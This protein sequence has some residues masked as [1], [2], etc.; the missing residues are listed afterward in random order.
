[1]LYTDLKIEDI[2]NL[3]QTRNRIDPEKIYPEG[4]FSTPARS[5]AVLVPFTR[6]END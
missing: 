5:A 3:I 1:V 2:K 6:V 4:F